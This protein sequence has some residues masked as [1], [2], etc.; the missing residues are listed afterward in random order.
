MHSKHSSGSTLLQ[1]SSLLVP[2]ETCGLFHT[3]TIMKKDARFLSWSPCLPPPTC[4]LGHN[5]KPGGRPVGVGELKL[6]HP[7]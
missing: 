5:K 6:H 2:E 3:A 1:S 7:S 4:A